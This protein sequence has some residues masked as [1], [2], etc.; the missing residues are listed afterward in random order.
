MVLQR[1]AKTAV[2]GAV[3]G[4]DQTVDQR[5][6]R[7]ERRI[8]A[9]SIEGLLEPLERIH[10]LSETEDEA[11]RVRA[12]VARGR[13]LAGHGALDTALELFRAYLPEFADPENRRRIYLLAAEL[14]EAEERIDEAIEA[15]RGRL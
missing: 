5:L 7:F 6:T 2:Y 12:L 8:A 11:L 3:L 4:S 13:V 10:H 9:G 1:D 15:Y 14:L